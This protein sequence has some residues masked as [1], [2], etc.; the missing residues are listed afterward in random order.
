MAALAPL[1]REL[2]VSYTNQGSEV[3]C[4]YHVCS[5][6]W[7]KNMVELLYPLPVDKTAYDDNK[8]NDFLHTTFIDL[9]KLTP[10]KCTQNGYV[11]ILLFYFFY[12]LFLDKAV[13][14]YGRMKSKI[15][16]T[17]ILDILPQIDSNHVSDGLFVNTAQMT[18]IQ[19]TMHTVNHIKNSLGLTYKYI[20]VFNNPK[21]LSMIQK[22]IGLGLYIGAALVE[23]SA[24]EH[25]SHA[26]HIVNVEKDTVVIKDSLEEKEYSG[27]IDEP[28]QFKLEGHTFH[29]TLDYCLFFLPCRSEPIEEARTPEQIYVFETWLDKYVDA[30]PEMIAPAPSIFSALKP[31]FNIGDIVK[32]RGYDYVGD[33]KIIKKRTEKN[34]TVEYNDGEIRR[35]NVLDSNLIKGGKSK[36]QRK[37]RKRVR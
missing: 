13:E 24:G 29:Y 21:L 9:R 27:K 36:R 25:S 14:K 19:Q 35:L 26:V 10:E 28:F 1:T 18:T 5:K 15:Y 37:S 34:Y 8:C 4:S 3:T 6:L 30:F 16:L 31:T 33:V 22:V 2:S 12:S 23:P 7:L 32:L 11:K 20:V 17:D